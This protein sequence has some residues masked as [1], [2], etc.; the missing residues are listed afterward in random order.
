MTKGAAAQNTAGGT[1]DEHDSDA[2]LSYVAHSGLKS[3]QGKPL[4]KNKYA[5][6]MDIEFELDKDELSA[7]ER[8][9]QREQ[10]QREHAGALKLAQCESLA[11]SSL[12]DGDGIVALPRERDSETSP[13]VQT[14]KDERDNKKSKARKLVEK[15]YGDSGLSAI[16]LATTHKEESKY[17]LDGWRYAPTNKVIRSSAIC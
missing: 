1:P 2:S 14:Q 4:P 13:S 17:H 9:A 10:E 7:V 16:D 11:G 15:K 12:A 8:A 3:E 6:D 5:W